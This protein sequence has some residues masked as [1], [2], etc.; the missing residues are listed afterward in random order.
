M[1]IFNIQTKN[2]LKSTF[3]DK[4]LNF[5]D[6]RL[7]FGVKCKKFFSS[8]N[9]STFLRLFCMFFSNSY[10]LKVPLIAY[11]SNIYPPLF[12][13]PTSNKRIRGNVA[14]VRFL[15]RA[16]FE[17]KKRLLF[18]QFSPPPNFFPTPNTSKKYFAKF[19]ISRAS[20]YLCRLIFYNN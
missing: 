2:R 17:N 15:L 19:F 10:F 7:N 20:A 9:C 11:V 1:P 16:L 18:A 3:Q 8:E 13:Y 4:R 14:G 6:K 12:P 5:Q